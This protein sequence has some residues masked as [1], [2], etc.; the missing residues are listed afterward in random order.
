M[1]VLVL[2]AFTKQICIVYTNQSTG[3]N[4]EN[5]TAVAF[6]STGQNALFIG[7]NATHGVVYNYDYGNHFLAIVP[8][9]DTQ[10]PGHKFYD[11][12]Y[13][14]NNPTQE[15]VIV[16]QSAFKILPNM[17]DT[18]TRITANVEDPNILD[19][20]FRDQS[21]SISRESQQV[22]IDHT[23]T[24]Y[25]EA[26]Y[27][28]GGVDMW[29]SMSIVLTAWYD[30]G[31]VGSASIPEPNWNTPD[32]RTRQFNITY[33]VNPGNAVINYPSAPEFIIDS[34]WV[35]PVV[36]PNDA[37]RLYI[38]VTFGN[39]TRMADSSFSNGAAADILDKNAAHN[40]VNSWDYMFHI[41][42]ESNT[43]SFEEAFE[44]FGIVET[45]SISVSG[46]PSGN[47]PPGS[48][49]VLLFNPSQII[50][51]SNTGYWV[52]VSI[53]DLLESGVGPTNIP[54]T[55]VSVR[56]SNFQANVGNSQIF[57][58][59]GIAGAG[60]NMYVWGLGG[61]PIT[62][63]QN[64]T[65]CVGDWVSNYNAAGLGLDDYTQ[66]DWWVT[67]NAGT[68]EGVYWAII[69]ITIDS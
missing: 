25:I 40:D 10:F 51:T 28:I 31:H 32:N 55:D 29:D 38:N 50:C 14:P 37:H 35:D 3:T 63:P 2:R 23:Y 4:G 47:T 8:G 66:L 16:G 44:E 11:I 65:T 22:D 15:A 43:N 62:S 67:V 7:H 54:A 69:T 30:E 21:T 27:T 18:S 20:D 61:S 39:Q 42:D 5:F 6:D 9:T 64:G 41:Y 58:M 13:M 12:G 49:D 26:N 52:N 36:Y 19:I 45:V 68:P 46:N 34:T 33:D 17:A 59:T 57:A 24:F 1:C 53:P 60:T 56:N 48:I